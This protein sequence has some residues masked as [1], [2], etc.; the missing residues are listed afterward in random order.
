[1]SLA[2]VEE[3]IA[4]AGHP[5]AGHTLSVAEVSEA[6]DEGRVLEIH[7]WSSFGEGEASFGFATRVGLDGQGRVHPT[8][9]VFPRPIP[10]A[11]RRPSRPIGEEIADVYAAFGVEAKWARR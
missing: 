3:L 6:V 1:M 5:V 2:L 10:L 9:L 4:A 11:L 7:Y 8:Y